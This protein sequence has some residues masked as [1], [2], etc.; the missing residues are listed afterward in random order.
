MS[1]GKRILDGLTILY[2]P[3]A[4]TKQKIS[5]AS[6][7]NVK[8]MLIK[9]SVFIVK[10]KFNKS[11]VA[12]HIGDLKRCSTIIM[13]WQTKDNP[14]FLFNNSF[15]IK[16]K[17]KVEDDYCRRTETE[18]IMIQ[19]MNLQDNTPSRSTR[20]SISRSSNI[21]RSVSR[22]VNRS[23]SKLS[24]R[25]AIKPPTQKS[26]PLKSEKY[27]NKELKKLIINWFEPEEMIST[28]DPLLMITPK[29]TENEIRSRSRSRSV[30]SSR[31]SKSSRH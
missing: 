24:N 11:I 31:R 6:N 22:S 20:K 8:N 29:T 2:A 5:K 4:L 23:R 30:Q 27:K 1:T 26:K 14:L 3:Q 7:E 12:K 21:G 15:K 9:H 25:P 10:I 19:N 17:S 18:P 28:N 16:S 13:E